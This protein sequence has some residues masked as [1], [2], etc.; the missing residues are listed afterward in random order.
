MTLGTT[1]YSTAY[2]QSPPWPKE[3]KLPSMQKQHNRKSVQQHLSRQVKRLVVRLSGD[4]GFQTRYVHLW[5]MQSSW[6]HFREHCWWIPD[7]R[8]S[9]HKYLDKKNTWWLWGV[10]KQFSWGAIINFHGFRRGTMTL[11]CVTLS[12][13]FTR[14]KKLWWGMHL[15]WENNR[16]VHYAKS[17]WT[18]ERS[19]TH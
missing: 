7:W 1:I 4:Y 5:N 15:I 8:Q 11:L 13:L 16:H 12:G 19:R 6:H 9:M 10:W 2:M 18:S 17:F 14:R 3:M